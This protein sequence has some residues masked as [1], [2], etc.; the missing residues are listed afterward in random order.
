MASDSTSIHTTNRSFKDNRLISRVYL[1]VL[2]H[3][4]NSIRIL[5]KDWPLASGI[6]ISRTYTKTFAG[7]PKETN[8]ILVTRVVGDDP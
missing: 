3:T 7:V 5:N 8:L 2:R 1:T 6:T 4:L